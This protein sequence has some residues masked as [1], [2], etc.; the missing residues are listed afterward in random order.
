MKQNPVSIKDTLVSDIRAGRCRAS[1]LNSEV[2]QVVDTSPRVRIGRTLIF[3]Q[4]FFERIII[5]GDSGLIG[6]DRKFAF[7]IKLVLP[8]SF[9]DEG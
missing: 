6:G 7:K 1:S 4:A 2:V 3:I 8:R 9:V 5:F